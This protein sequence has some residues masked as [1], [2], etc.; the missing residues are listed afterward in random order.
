[1]LLFPI[2]AQMWVLEIYVSNCP[3]PINVTLSNCCPNVAAWNICLKLSPSLQQWKR[4]YGITARVGAWV[5]TRKANPQL[6]ISISVVSF[7]N[8]FPKQNYI[9]KL[10]ICVRSGSSCTHKWEE[11]PIKTVKSESPLGNIS[12]ASF[13][14]NKP[15]LRANIHLHFAIGP[16]H[17]RAP[18]SF[19]HNS[20]FWYIFY[21][22]DLGAIQ[23]S[24]ALPISFAPNFVLHAPN[25]TSYS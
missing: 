23:L 18:I 15:Q 13:L 17:A 6:T 12:E 11:Q 8:L 24:R 16:C 20:T 5:A 22:S 9:R 4:D 1:M 14:R 19:P 21:I 2:V 25:F 10:A 3:P 7:H